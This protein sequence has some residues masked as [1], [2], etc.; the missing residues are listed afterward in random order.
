MVLN[1]IAAMG[2]ALDLL[3]IP[4]FIEM[5]LQRF[6]LPARK[7]SWTHWDDA[8]SR[9]VFSPRP[10]TLRDT[11]LWKG[12][13]LS[14]DVAFHVDV[15][16]IGGYRLFG[17]VISEWMLVPSYLAATMAATRRNDKLS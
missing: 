4:A 6:G 9:L 10:G 7:L 13:V 15:I 16:G 5:E 1:V 3:L 17:K 11:L 14:Y 12:L 2:V 8:F